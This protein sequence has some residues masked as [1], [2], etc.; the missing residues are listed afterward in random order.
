LDPHR[1]ASIHRVRETC[2]FPEHML[3]FCPLG[4]IPPMLNAHV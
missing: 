3:L 4:I 1:R 2:G